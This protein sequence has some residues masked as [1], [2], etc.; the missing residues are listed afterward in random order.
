MTRAHLAALLGLFALAGC[1]EKDVGSDSAD[2]SGGT[3]FC[4]GARATVSLPE[5]DL[6][7]ELELSVLLAHPD[8]QAANLTLSYSVAGG[9]YSELTLIDAALTNLATSPEGESYSFTWDSVSDLGFTN[10]TDVEIV[11]QAVSVCGPWNQGKLSGVSV[12]NE[13]V[14]P[15]TCSAS[16]VTPSETQ[17]GTFA[18]SFVLTHE[19]EVE[20]D[21]TVEFSTD[22]GGS[23]S[24]LTSAF[25]DCDGDGVED[26]LQDLTTSAAGAEHCLTWLSERDIDVDEDAVVVR[27]SCEV[28]GEVEGTADTESFAVHN[29]PTPDAGELIFTELM[30]RPSARDGEYVEVYSLAHHTLNLNGLAVKMWYAGDDTSSD[31]PVGEHVIQVSSTNLALAPGERLVLGASRDAGQNGCVDVDYAWGGDVSLEDDAILALEADSVR[32]AELSFADADGWSLPRR[33]AFSL[34]PSAHNLSDWSDPGSW[35]A[36]TSAIGTCAEFP[37]QA[38]LGSPGVSN[39]SCGG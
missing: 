11:A 15:P 7:G 39:D 8:S 23:F 3:D 24:T 31:A 33:A 6:S 9:A 18:M 5:G 17:A 25:L 21:V 20:A 1:G 32:V 34:D 36:A 2:D 38:D 13:E 14:T 22:G 29:D 37:D 28:D 4:G 19:E 12:L 27:I 26:S 35:C 10:A 30:T 16:V